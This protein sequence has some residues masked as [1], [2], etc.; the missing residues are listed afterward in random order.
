[1][2]FFIL[3]E[4]LRIIM[5]HESDK[6][7]IRFMMYNQNFFG[8][9]GTEEY[10]AL[11]KLLYDYRNKDLKCISSKERT[12][13]ANELV[14]INLGDSPEKRMDYFE[15]LRKL[16]KNFLIS[17]E[18]RYTP[19]EDVAKLVCGIITDHM[20][21]IN[22]DESLMHILDQKDKFRQLCSVLEVSTTEGT[23][24]SLPDKIVD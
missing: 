10:Y 21:C 12:T 9:H 13:L 23:I 20:I 1:M 3:Y 15:Y 19:K 2:D 17:F 6:R 5:E 22:K 14:R 16:L 7:K 11:F 8:R 18:K 4:E 24:Y